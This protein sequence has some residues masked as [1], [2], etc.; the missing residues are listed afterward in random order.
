MPVLYGVNRGEAP[1]CCRVV[2]ESVVVQAS[3]VVKFLT[4]E[5]VMEALRSVLQ[6]LAEHVV[7]IGA[8]RGAPL[9]RHGA[10]AAQMV[11][12]EVMPLR[13]GMACI[14]EGVEAYS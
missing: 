3:P 8:E 9:V 6:W 10:D 1:E 11:L 13:I 12:A 7:V 4:R 14:D 5:A 2:A